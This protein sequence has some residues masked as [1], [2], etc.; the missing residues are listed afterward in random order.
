MA[1]HPPARCARW[2]S[3]LV[4][5]LASCDRK[6]PEPKPAMVE[7][8][9]V[10]GVAR[11][12]GARA[13]TFSSST[14]LLAGLDEVLGDKSVTSSTTVGAVAVSPESATIAE[15]PQPSEPDTIGEKST[16]TDATAI[17]EPDRVDPNAGIAGASA[18]TRTE[19]P[20]TVETLAPSTSPSTSTSGPLALGGVDALEVGDRVQVQTTAGAWVAG[21]IISIHLD[22]TYDIE[23]DGV[24]ERGLAAVKLR[25]R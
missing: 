25:K 3:V 18:S 1:D 21:T 5:A 9:G 24:I 7:V 11:K 14:G 6:P 8:E 17:A 12:T 2:L 19:K 10:D 15:V 13:N 22:G 16:S 20:E 23:R 4:L